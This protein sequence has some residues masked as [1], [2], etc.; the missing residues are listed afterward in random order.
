MIVTKR[1]F[2]NDG[3][4]VMIV[5]F[6]SKYDA[7]GTSHHAWVAFDIDTGYASAAS[8]TD[9]ELL[10]P[11]LDCRFNCNKAQITKIVTRLELP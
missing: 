3:D 7:N 2:I 9:G 5:H 8:D 4:H 10:G 6:R 11:L 1:E